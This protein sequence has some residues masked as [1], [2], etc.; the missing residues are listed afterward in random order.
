LSA[1]EK[2]AADNIEGWAR[3][4]RQNF[5]E[6]QSAEA[7][8]RVAQTDPRRFEQLKQAAAKVEQ[9]VNGWSQ[10]YAQAAQQRTAHEQQLHQQANAHVRAVYQNYSKQQDELFSKA[11]PEM[12]D[13]R[14]AYELREAVRKS[15][16]DVGFN[17]AELQEA[18]DGHSGVPLRDARVQQVLRKAA[19][20]DRMHANAKNIANNRAGIPPVQQPGTYRPAGAGAEENVRAL[21][22]QLEIATGNKALRLAAQL[23]RARRAAG[24]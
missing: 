6:L 16:R 10:R 12:R 13:T 18:W 5:P 3:W 8:N 4:A 20:Y 22:R 11:A 23:T 7:V 19:L 15:L 14:Q 24:M 1:A 17:D 2:Q 9:Q 21:E